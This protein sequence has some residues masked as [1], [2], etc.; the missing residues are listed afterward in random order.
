MANL[1]IGCE[2]D[3]LGNTGLPSKNCP[4]GI[5]TGLAIQNLVANDGTLNRIS[6]AS[7]ITTGWT[8][9]LVQAINS[10]RLF[11]VINT[12]EFEYTPGAAVWKEDNQ[13]NK[14]YVR[15][16]P[17]A[18]KLEKWNITPKFVSKF[19]A[20]LCQQANIGT[21]LLSDKGVRGYNVDGYFQPIPLNDLF[22]NFMEQNASDPTK[23]MFEATFRSD[24]D[25]SK[26]YFLTWAELNTT[27]SAQVGLLDANITIATAAVD[28]GT[29]TTVGL[30]FRSDYAQGLTTVQDITG[31]VLAD[32]AIHNVTANASITGVSLVEVADDE[33]TLT[34][35]SATTADVIRVSTLNSTGFE[36]LVTFAQ[37]A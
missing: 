3:N 9:M 10:K 4:Q 2:C 26:L 5:V 17:T 33:Y 21:Y 25:L 22:V 29:N 19:D 36:G 28:G 13:G 20:A 16:A 18:W 34:Y 14:T 37:P 27:Y 24:F 32:L 12:S 1:V 8:S 23:A 7:A 6:L 31:L 11:P 35:P 15:T 30:R